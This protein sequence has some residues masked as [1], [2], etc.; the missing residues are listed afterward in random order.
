MKRELNFALRV[1]MIDACNYSCQYCPRNTSMENF[2]PEDLKN[3]P[4]PFEIF[5]NGVVNLLNKYNFTKMVITGGEPLLSP[6]LADFL[7]AVHGCGIKIELD[8]NGSLYNPTIWE[9]IK[10]NVDAVKVSFDSLNQ[11]TYQNLTNSKKKQDYDSAMSFIK[12]TIEDGKPTT[13]NVVLTKKNIHDIP[14]LVEFA[15]KHGAN[16]SIL[17]LYYTNETRNFWLQQFIPI[18]VLISTLEKKY[19]QVKKVDV[20]GCEFFDIAINN[21]KNYIRFKASNSST[22]RDEKCDDCE[23]YCHEGIFAL[24]LS[25]QGW[26]TT[27]QL[28]NGEGALLSDDDVM[29]GALIDRIEKSE[30]DKDSFQ[31]LICKHNLEI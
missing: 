26:L 6:K 21:N 20:F 4:M 29:I 27:C 18:D 11:K 5:K 7:V 13:I 30:S 28:N 24:R 16:L 8:S 19:G 22:M 15:I 14:E 31:R 25:I 10:D 23:N 1:S 9:K 2:C 12:Q 17:D 3:K